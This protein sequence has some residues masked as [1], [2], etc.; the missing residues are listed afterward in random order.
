[1]VH[2]RHEVGVVGERGDEADAAGRRGRNATGDEAG[3]RY[4]EPRARQLRQ[5]A[6]AEMAQPAAEADELVGRRTV[7]A[8]LVLDDGDLTLR[9]RE[10]EIQGHEALARAR[11]EVLEHVLVAG[12]VGNDELEPFGRLDK[13]AR[14][15]DREPP[16]VVRQRVD[17]DDGVLARLDDLVEV[18]DRAEAG[19]ERQRAVLADRL[20]A[21]VTR[22]ARRRGAG[23]SGP[24]CQTAPR[25][26]AGWR[27]VRSLAGRS[28]WQATV[29][30]GR[31]SRHAMCSTNRVLPQP[32]GPLSITASR[33]AWHCSK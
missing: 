13:L 11:L 7:H 15:F 9:W 28:S 14:L 30:S 8:T 33:R 10:A 6:V 4:E 1:V 20:A 12:V 2:R 29:A 16:P 26:R 3:R 21:A 25:P 23:V 22:G 32:V 24:S 19:V 5:P 18:A 27:P 17:H 31:P